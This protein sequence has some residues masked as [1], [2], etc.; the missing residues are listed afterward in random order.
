MFYTLVWELG[1]G[2]VYLNK[3]GMF[4]LKKDWSSH[5]LFIANGNIN[6]ILEET[7]FL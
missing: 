7:L 3:I 4:I 5:P 6:Y 1:G 2:K